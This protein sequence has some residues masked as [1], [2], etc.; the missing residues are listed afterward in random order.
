MPTNNFKLFDQNK[1]NLLSDIEYLNATQRLN[2]VQ[3]GVA[4]SQLQNKFAYQVSLV[5]YAIAQIM[6]QNGLDASDTLAVSAFVGNLGGSLL[7]KVADKA[8]TAEAVAGVLENKYISPATMKAAA[9][10]LSGGVMTGTL[11]MNNNQIINLPTPTSSSEPATKGYVDGMRSFVKVFEDSGVLSKSSTKGFT[12]NTNI[13]LS[14]IYNNPSQYLVKFSLNGTAKIINGEK[15][16]MFISLE[17]LDMG[18]SYRIEKQN[19][20]SNVNISKVYSYSLYKDFW[21]NGQ[22]EYFVSGIHD[23]WPYSTQIDSNFSC[24][25]HIGTIPEKLTIR[26]NVASSPWYLNLNYKIEMYRV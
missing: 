17:Y 13:K 6:N 19:V 26:V 14:D 15:Q 9:L 18:F 3:T 2:G 5:A 16:H 20:I 8:S 22:Q 10:L 1:A 25:Y 11:D 12:Q 21:N 7:Q 23:T 4:S 24:S